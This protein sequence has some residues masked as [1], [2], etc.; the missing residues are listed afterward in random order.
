MATITVQHEGSEIQVELPAGY[1]SS[2]QVEK[3]YIRRGS[4]ELSENYI[5]KREVERRWVQRG[6]AANDQKVIDAVLLK[7][8][9][10]ATG[11]ADDILMAELAAEK[12][13]REAA[14][15][16]L[17]KLASSIRDRD[18]AA[19]AKQ[20]FKDAVFENP[21][22]DPVA[23]FRDE[24][25]YDLDLG[26]TVHMQDGK[27]A[28]SDNANETRPYRDALERFEKLAQED[29]FKSMARPSETI[30]TTPN[31]ET[32]E[33]EAATRLTRKVLIGDPQ[34]MG[35]YLDKHG[36]EAFRKLPIS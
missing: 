36:E 6:E 34:R 12:G 9:P 3:D 24:F 21:F 20:V 25:Q 10:K 27:A 5:L 15:G 22:A 7:H 18:V 4:S 23:R 35:D 28:Y 19:A 17:T 33:P 11:K 13:K 2:A 29:A 31:G 8:P 1:V 30:T 16:T 26:Y 14:E 32:P